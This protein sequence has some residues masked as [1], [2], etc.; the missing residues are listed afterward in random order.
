MRTSTAT[1]LIALAS[2]VGLS[3]LALVLAQSGMQNESFIT[4]KSHLHAQGVTLQE[5][6]IRALNSGM[7]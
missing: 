5:P 4:R 1:T 6:H 2:F 7:R 3:A